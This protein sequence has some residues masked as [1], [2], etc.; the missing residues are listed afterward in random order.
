[1]RR[2]LNHDGSWEKKEE[3]IKRGFGFIDIFD[4]DIVR[5]ITDGE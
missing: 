1:M 5:M 4:F 2:P 3:K